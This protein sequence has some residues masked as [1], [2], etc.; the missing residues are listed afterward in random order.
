MDI[1]H[2]YFGGQQLFRDL[3][4]E[5]TRWKRAVQNEMVAGGGLMGKKQGIKRATKKM[6]SQTV[7][8]G[9]RANSGESKV[10]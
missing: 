10:F 5:I 1:P 9:G 6:L 4:G 7:I 3:P 8:F 2:N